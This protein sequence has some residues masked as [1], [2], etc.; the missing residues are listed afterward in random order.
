MPESPLLFSVPAW[1]SLLLC[2]QEVEE[3]KGQGV[4]E[5]KNP[6]RVCRATGQMA[7]GSSTFRLLDFS[8]QNSTEQSQ[9]V[10][11]NKGRGQ[12]VEELSS[13]GVQKW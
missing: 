13:R 9:N 8:T 10:Y 3:S 2:S 12:K 7:V 4:E 5:W 6:G 11:E 1:G